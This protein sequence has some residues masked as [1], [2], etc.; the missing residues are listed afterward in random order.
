[1]TQPLFRLLQKS[2]MF[3]RD[4]KC[5]SI[6]QQCYGDGY[7]ALKQILFQ[8]H[9]VF[10]DQ[11]ATLITRYP[12]QRDFSLLKYYS[13]FLDYLQLRAFISDID[14][15]LDE[16]HELDIFING[17]KYN[18]FLNRV[19][20]DE[21]KLVSLRHKYTSAQIVETLE[22]Y[23]N[24]PDSPMLQEPATATSPHGATT[25]A[26]WLAT[27]AST[28]TREPIPVSPLHSCQRRPSC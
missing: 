12:T 2:D 4:S 23:L 27:A 24:E 14:S 11:P 22:T 9:P 25:A 7:K 8:S 26:S 28:S 1:M 17:T 15:S 16:S 21:R 6:V 19:T 3:P 5:V 10:H 20:R 18:I 13:L